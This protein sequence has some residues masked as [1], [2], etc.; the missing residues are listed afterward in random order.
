MPSTTDKAVLSSRSFLASTD[1]RAS[2]HM[3]HAP[4]R[5]SSSR[6]PSI[7]GSASVCTMRPSA[8]NTTRSA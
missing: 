8:R 2:V 1:F 5:F 7:V 3:A 6:I 4:S